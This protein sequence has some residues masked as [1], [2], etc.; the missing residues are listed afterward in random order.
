MHPDAGTTHDNETV[1]PITTPARLVAAD[2][3]PVHGAEPIVSDTSFD[4]LLLV[5]DAFDERTRTKYRP[6]ATPLAE[7]VVEELPV[8]TVARL[9]NPELEPASRMYDV[10]AHPPAGA[11]HARVMDVPFTVDV[12]PVG[13]SGGVAHV[14]TLRTVTVVSLDAPLVPL[15]L[16]ARTRTK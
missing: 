5:P 8:G 9:V 1:V 7:S 2:G 15:A 11:C 14:S 16:R 3:T 13:A 4:V 10:A 12:S 6:A